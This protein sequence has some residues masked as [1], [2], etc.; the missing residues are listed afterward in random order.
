MPSVVATVR[1][2][3]GKLPK[4]APEDRPEDIPEDG[5]EAVTVEMSDQSSEPLNRSATDLLQ[6]RLLPADEI[7][8]SPVAYL[9]SDK[10][11]QVLTVLSQGSA[12]ITDTTPEVRSPLQTQLS[13]LTQAPLS[14][15]QASS[16]LPAAAY[17]YL[18]L[19][20]SAPPLY[21]VWQEGETTVLIVRV[22]PALSSLIKA[23]STAVDPLQHVYWMYTLT[24]LWMALEPIPQ[25]RSSL[26]QAD[27]LGIDSDQSVRVQQFIM[28]GEQPPQ[29][30]DLKAFLQ[31]L[32]AQP[33]R[34]AIAP[35]RQI[36]QLILTVTSAETLTQLRNELETIGEALL[37][38][39]DAITPDVA[40]SPAAERPFPQ[41]PSTQPEDADQSAASQPDT[42]QPDTTQ[43]DTTQ[44]DTTQLDTSQSVEPQ[45]E[46]ANL[47]PIH[48]EEDPTALEPMDDID[49]IVL[50]ELTDSSDNTVVLPMKLV[51][52]A[53]AGQTD[54]GRQ[55]DHNEDYFVI[56]SSAYK[57]AS[58]GQQRTQAHGLYVLCDGM[59]GHAGGEV[60]S[61]LATKT[62]IAYFAEHWPQ[63][64]ADSR[65]LPLPAK[66][67][68]IEAVRQ[69][70]Q[71][72]YDVNEKEERAGHERMGTTLVMVLLQNTDAVVVHVGDSRLYQHTRRTG[73]RQITTDH[74]VGQREIQRG[75][76]P[77]VA[78]DRPDAYQLT[79]ALGPR[80]QEELSPSV[81]YLSFSEDALLLLCSDGLSDN[82]LVEDHLQSHIDPLTRGHKELE[83]GLDDLVN[84]ANEVNGHDNISAIAL[85][86][87]VSPD[88]GR[89]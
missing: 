52:L 53:D 27:N 42:T 12:N 30:S 59:G 46:T 78:Y 31:S 13:Q 25:W 79:Q 35:L 58:N 24:D 82:N 77:D 33:H 23:F 37:A 61:Q 85:R 83:A 76:A 28:P 45:P 50:P 38:T 70:N 16:A 19:P 20:A 49:D 86:L 65:S 32:L 8:L 57:Q 9:G 6:A 4:D 48:L 1:K 80:S 72:I 10:R 75:V 41:A 69:A 51:A 18:L 81:S 15:L 3:S 7:E 44:L 43:L 68:L 56:A 60:A 29:L 26:L 62:L 55:R 73:L 89:L 34:G 17:P 88:M 87:Q 64:Q 84:L 47:E 71:A 5:S 21:D 22:R 54:V 39:P 11:Y 36:R 40:S 67:T 74:E 66:A 2:T 14:T 63:P